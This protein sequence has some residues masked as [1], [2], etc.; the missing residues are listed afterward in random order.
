VREE[1]GAD[2]EIHGRGKCDQCAAEREVNA[3]ELVSNTHGPAAGSLARVAIASL[4]RC[5][6]G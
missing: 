2:A 1:Q 5:L 6:G 4:P 3:G